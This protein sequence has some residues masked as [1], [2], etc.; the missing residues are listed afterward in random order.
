VPPGSAVE[1]PDGDSPQAPAAAGCSTRH[2][3]VADYYPVG[4]DYSAAADYPAGADY[5]ADEYYLAAADYPAGADYSADE[6][7]LAAADYPVGAD[8]SA[9]DYS[10]DGHS[11]A[12]CCWAAR[13]PAE[14]LACHY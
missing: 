4:A 12:G 1:V 9:A 5:S 14:S 7:Y 3:L 6:Y 2:C 8:Y 11:Q 10:A 13:V